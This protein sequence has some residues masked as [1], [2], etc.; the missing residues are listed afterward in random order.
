MSPSDTANDKEVIMMLLCMSAFIDYLA[1]DEVV[2]LEQFVGE[3]AQVSAHH[4]VKLAYE[5]RNSIAEQARQTKI[6]LPELK[7]DM[8]KRTAEFLPEGEV[9]EMSEERKEWLRAVPLNNDACERRFGITAEEHRKKPNESWAMSEATTLAQTNKPFDYIEQLPA[10][11][12]KKDEMWRKARDEQKREQERAKADWED[13]KA[14]KREKVKKTIEEAQRRERKA[15]KER[16]EFKDVEPINTQEELEEHLNEI[17]DG[18][19]RKAFLRDQI[20]NWQSKG[21]TRN[22]LN[23]SRGSAK[24]MK[25]KL[26]EYLNKRLSAAMLAKPSVPKSRKHRAP[27]ASEAPKPEKKAKTGLSA[28]SSKSK[29]ETV[30][31]KPKA[32]AKATPS[33]RGREASHKPKPSKASVKPKPKKRA[34]TE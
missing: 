34:K 20:R 32:K 6:A 11:E 8:K 28:K 31:A 30:P 22:E 24:A 15:A 21:A 9:A 12:E 27:A 26:V 4:T 29:K 3:P 25:A 19:V 7:S 13:M 33:K 1:A 2:L 23:F 17:Q 16:A 18:D 5:S 14:R 10:T